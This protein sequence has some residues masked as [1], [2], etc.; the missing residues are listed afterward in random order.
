MCKTCLIW[1]FVNDWLNEWMDGCTRKQKN[2][3]QV[4]GQDKLDVYLVNMAIFTFA[5]ESTLGITMPRSEEGRN[6]QAKLS[7][8]ITRRTICRMSVF[9]FIFVPEQDPNQTTASQS[10]DWLS[11]SHGRTLGKVHNRYGR[12]AVELTSV[13]WSQWWGQA[14]G[15]HSA[16]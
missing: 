3:S 4:S 5:I 2:K 15:Q 12:G 8:K 9:Y 13:K 1:L 7:D 14:R 11:C 16:L 6:G 10:E